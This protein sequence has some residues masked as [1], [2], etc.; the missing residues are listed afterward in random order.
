M[1]LRKQVNKMT[2]KL[3]REP[4]N[5]PRDCP[6]CGKLHVT[7]DLHCEHCL[8]NLLEDQK[9]EMNRAFTIEN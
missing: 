3:V 6:R 5:R 9:L 2:V 7:D 8:Y 1:R 4:Y